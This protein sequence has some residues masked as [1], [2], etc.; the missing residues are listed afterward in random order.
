[1]LAIVPVWA[2]ITTVLVTIM[3]EGGR[4][5]ARARRD[6][7]AQRATEAKL[8]PPAPGRSSPAADPDRVGARSAPR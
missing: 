4:W 6:T 8:D 2:V 7:R 3:V 5:M 1:V